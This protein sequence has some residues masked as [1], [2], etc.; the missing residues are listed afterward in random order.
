MPASATRPASTRPYGGLAKAERVAPR[1]A[2][3]IAAG[4]ELFGTQGFRG[5]TVRGICAA[6]GLTD[7]YFYESFASLEALLAEVYGTVR[8][9]FARSLPEEYL[10]AEGWHG[11][12]ADVERQ[13]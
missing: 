5:A 13:V 9:G 11:D 3:F 12:E 1:R 4:I 6:A 10:G 2:R 8:D 7:R